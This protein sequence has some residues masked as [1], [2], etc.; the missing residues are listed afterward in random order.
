MSDYDYEDSSTGQKSG[1]VLPWVLL[2]FV[3]V[4]AGMGMFF[5]NMEK[6]QATL[7]MEKIKGEYESGKKHEQALD[8]QRQ[9]LEKQLSDMKSDRDAL[10]AAKNDATRKV[11][12][13]TQQLTL[14][15]AEAS[16]SGKGKKGKSGKKVLVVKGKHR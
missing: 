13:L 8:R 16:D 6:E 3:A 2:T 15:K 5:F 14:T 4:G 11:D 10:E 1:S 7:A 9:D 12:E